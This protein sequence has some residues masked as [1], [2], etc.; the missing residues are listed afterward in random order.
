[1]TLF[2][3]VPLPFKIALAAE[4]RLD[5]RVLGF[6]LLAAVA[7]SLVFGLALAWQTANPHL[8]SAIK[9]SHVGRLGKSVLGNA[10]VVAQ[11]ALSLALLVGAGLLTRSLWNLRNVETGYRT[12]RVLLAQF[13]LDPREFTAEKG[14]DFYQRLLDRARALPGVEM[15]SLTKN[16]PINPLRMKKPPVAAAGTEPQREEDWLNAEP[17]FISPGYFQTLS[18]RL[19]DGRDFDERDAAGAPP[20]VIV[21]EM[22]ARRLWPRRPAV[23]KQLRIDGEKEPYTVIAVA[24]NLKYRALTEATPPYYYLP[25]AQNYLREMTLQART[26]TAPL[27]LAA[28]I[29]RLAHELNANAFIREIST[30]DGQIAQALAQP[31]MTALSAGILGLL[32]LALAV[33]G[34]YS[35]MAYAVTRRTPEIGIRIALGAQRADVLLLVLGQGMKMA[36]SGVALGLLVALG[37]TR[38]L[39]QMLYGVS[40]TDPATFAGIA[41]LLVA[42]ALAASFVP[43]WRATKVDPLV[44]LRCE[45]GGQI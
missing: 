15:V 45:F 33:T 39:A 20:V 35:V 29:R 23:G 1:M 3:A 28:P 42:V 37:L 2:A 24:P 26:T 36:L 38:L 22:L 13:D 7:T 27:G 10:L 17:D 31:R 6:S 21:N 18:V 43:A 19:L 9:G 8:L 41:L 32:A 40:A 25:L 44:A 11:I 4:L 16:V 34:L 12:D 5:A 14:L 30:L